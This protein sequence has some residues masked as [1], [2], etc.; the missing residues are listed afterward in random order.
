VVL[1]MPCPPKV[2]ILDNTT[3]LAAL[4][5]RLPAGMFP[6][7]FPWTCPCGVRGIPGCSKPL[8]FAKRVHIAI[9]D[10]HQLEETHAQGIISAHGDGSLEEVCQV[11]AIECFSPERLSLFDAHVESALSIL[12]QYGVHFIKP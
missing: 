6:D 8:C 12:W 3:A 11:V 2:E 1:S 5:A 9:I 4:R 10:W 7:N